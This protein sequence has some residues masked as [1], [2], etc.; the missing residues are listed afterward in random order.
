VPVDVV[1]VGDDVVEMTDEF[2][3]GYKILLERI[4]L[5]EPGI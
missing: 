4:L 1:L 2:E 3:I 5:L